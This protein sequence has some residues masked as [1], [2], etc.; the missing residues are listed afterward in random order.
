MSNAKGPQAAKLKLSHKHLQSCTRTSQCMA[1]PGPWLSMKFQRKGKRW[2]WRCKL[3]CIFAC[4]P[5]WSCQ[6]RQGEALSFLL[7][8]LDPFW[9]QPG[10]TRLLLLCWNG[11]S[12]SG[13]KP[14]HHLTEPCTHPLCA[15]RFL[16]SLNH[17][18]AF[19]GRTGLGQS[20]FGEAASGL[21]PRSLPVRL[22]QGG[23]ERS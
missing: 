14:P 7:R 8:W 1:S 6:K 18:T 21:G 10:G 16:Q 22:S 15:A 3:L 17:A 12:H 2:T 5:E 4:G 11:Q 9:P 23:S 19:G 20:A 13:R